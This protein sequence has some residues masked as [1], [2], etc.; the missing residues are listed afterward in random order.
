MERS[1]TKVESVFYE[2]KLT[3]GHACSYLPCSIL[4]R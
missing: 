3:V 1:K 4:R 2:N